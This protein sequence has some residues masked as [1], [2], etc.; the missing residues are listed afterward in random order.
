MSLSWILMRVGWG[1]MTCSCWYSGPINGRFTMEVT[2]ERNT[3][4]PSHTP[5]S[6]RWRRGPALYH[7]SVSDLNGLTLTNTSCLLRG[8][9]IFQ[10][11]LSYFLPNKHDRIP[12]NN[13]APISHN[14]T[15][16][17]GPLVPAASR[18]LPL[19]WTTLRFGGQ[20]IILFFL[21]FSVRLCWHPRDPSVP[22]KL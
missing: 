7:H 16:Q 3:V 19:L 5:D 13:P 18:I 4:A 20:A 17:A 1:M 6:S 2:L 12:G 22:Q 8:T 21:F 9:I 10:F 15:H 14:E 11:S